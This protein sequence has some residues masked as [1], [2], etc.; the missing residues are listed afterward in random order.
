M[1]SDLRDS[2]S[3]GQYP[4]QSTLK[5]RKDLKKQEQKTVVF[6][7]LALLLWIGLI[8]GGYFFSMKHLRQTEQNFLNQINALQQ[9]NQRIQEDITATMQLLHDELGNF[10]GEVAQVRG[11]MNLIR[12]ELELT[13][14]SLTGTDQTRLSLQERITELDGQLA[15]L[16]GQLKKLEEAVRAL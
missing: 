16:K 4:G 5:N 9:E 8:A 7:I 10:S 11:E 12:E 14:E 15:A 1:V 2:K 13:G 3:G 6:F